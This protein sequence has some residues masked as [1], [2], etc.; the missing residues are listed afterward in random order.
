MQASVIVVI[1]YKQQDSFFNW[2]RPDRWTKTSFK[3]YVD[4]CSDVMVNANDSI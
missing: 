1:H 3:Q 2:F 4:G